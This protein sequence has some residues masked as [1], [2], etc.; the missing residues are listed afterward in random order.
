M[1]D[2]TQAGVLNGQLLRDAF[3]LGVLRSQHQPGVVT[4]LP[5]VLQSL[6]HT[7][8]VEKKKIQTCLLFHVKSGWS[9]KINYI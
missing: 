6:Q 7:H 3:V 8:N 5:Q 1:L 9:N 4:Q 2:V